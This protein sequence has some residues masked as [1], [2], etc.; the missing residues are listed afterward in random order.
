MKQM[1]NTS[2]IEGYLYSHELKKKVSGP[3]AANPGI[4][5][6]TGTISIATDDALLNIVPVHFTYVTN[7]T[8]KNSPNA[9]FEL[10]NNIVE[11]K[12]CSVMSHGI[13]KAA[14]LRV[15]SSIG[16]NEFYSDRNGTEEFVSVKRNEGG[17]VH[18]AA[19]MEEDEKKRNKF[20]CDM[21]I[22]GTSRL[23][24]D[25]D[26]GAKEKLIL[27]GF[28]FDFKNALLPV[29]F[30]VVS[31][32]AMNYFESLE[33]TKR[34][35]IL[36][37]VQGYQISETI[38]RTIEE[39]SAFGEPSVREVRSSKKDFVINWAA[40]ET[41]LWDD[42]GTMTEEELDKKLTERAT[43]V[44]TLKQ[45]NDDYKASKANEGNALAQ[46]TFNF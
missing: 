11:E 33:P 43:Y 15:D 42:E 35:P 14:K 8:K 27:R 13:D 9:T 4:E 25:E 36:T 32:G 12:V 10:L 37:R 26:T 23:E 34:H 39:E 45:R 22:T 40:K 20:D 2:H 18:T 31:P 19:P 6:I 17:F 38:V 1:K 7:L 29:E 5:Y 46:P 28:I 24:A 44:A 21:L 30:S 41:Y 3:K 16:L